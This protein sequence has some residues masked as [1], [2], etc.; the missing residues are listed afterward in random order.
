MGS[1]AE[2]PDPERLSEL[3]E[4]ACALSGAGRAAFLAEECGSDAQLKA[5][6]ASLLVA[7]D[8]APDWLEGMAA[9]VLPEALHDMTR[10]HWPLGHA[11]SRYHVDA[12]IGRGGMGVVYRARDLTLGRTVALKFL[13]PHLT[14]DRESRSRLE[15]EAKAASSLDHPNIAVIHEIGSVPAPDDPDGGDRLFIAMAYYGGE[16]L[17]ET[18]ARGPLPIADAVRY[19]K[20]IAD[21]L[22][23]AHDAGIVHRDIKPANVMVTERGEAKILDFGVSRTQGSDLTRQGVALG[24]L[25]YMSP[26]QTRGA[27]VDHRTDV[28]SLGV[29]LYEMLAGTRP[30]D[31][32]DDVVRIHAIRNEVPTPLHD[33]RP[34]CSPSL[35]RVVER[36]MA[37]DPAARYQH[38]AGIAADLLVETGQ[39]A[40]VDVPPAA[41]AAEAASAGE[42]G[43]RRAPSLRQFVAAGALVAAFAAG[44]GILLFRD[45]DG[46]AADGLLAAAD[47]EPGASRVV[48][49][50]FATASADSDLERL[51][52]DLALA[53]AAALDGIDDIRT[54]DPFATLE[55]IRD[56]G[57]LSLPEVRRL[58]RELNA[59]RF[60]HGALSRSG[61]RLRL[62]A[63]WY[64]TGGASALA[65]AS[66]SADD[67]DGLTQA[68]T[69]ALL[70]QLWQSK[71]PAL[72]GGAISMKSAVPSARRAY[73]DGERALAQYDLPAAIE[74]F[75]RAFA[76]DTTFW[77]AFWRSFTPRLY[78]EDPVEDG[79]LVQKI[80]DR[81]WE[82]PRADRL[83]LEASRM[84]RSD[85][86]RV[87][88]MELH[89]GTYPDHPLL[90]WSY[91]NA[92][93]HR[94]TY[95]GYS[96]GEA[97]SAFERV[98]VLL[99]RF[100]RAWDHLLWTA[101]VRADSATAVR[102]AHEAARLDGT[103]GI[104]RLRLLRASLFDH[105]ATEAERL[106]QFVDFI[107]SAPPHLAENVSSGLVADGF[108]ALQIQVNRAARARGTGRSLEAALWRG[109]A[110][111]W[112]A[113]G[114]WD[115]ALVATDRWVA[116]ASRANADAELGAYRLATAGVL[117]GGV[118]P[119]RAGA[120]RRAAAQAIGRT[121]GQDVVCDTPSPT[122]D[123]AA[124]AVRP[125]PPMFYCE[126]PVRRA[127]YQRS[128]MIWLDGLLAYLRQDAPG[129]ARARAALVTGRD[130]PRS[131]GSRF[132]SSWDSVSRPALDR[133]L[134]ALAEALAGDEET[135]AR[136]LSSLEMEVANRHSVSQFA[137]FHP[138]FAT[139]NRLLAARLLSR[140]DRLAD[141][142]LLLNWHEAILPAYS[143]AWN[144]AIG[145]VT[146]LD[147]AEIAELSGDSASAL[148]DNQRFLSWHDLP[149][150]ALRPLTDRAIAGV[151]R[152]SR[153]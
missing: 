67:L 13:R 50:P 9:G 87:R 48:V 41:A 151:Q 11:V 33:L 24:T 15:T 149:D 125:G 80:I 130:L 115:S 16:T 105:E 99:P 146:L 136:T 56:P 72:D 8:R 30:F 107:L 44:A 88:Q 152:L 91:A 102:A 126:G 19:A 145:N 113:R 31:A 46:V 27:P 12:V 26:E 60:I 71:P 45:N 3:F 92:L 112:A 114:A 148:R 89:L 68:A 84:S 52:R 55:Q 127:V 21:G 93:G 98:L 22:A 143:S 141:A 142:A 133:S 128:D 6:L 32:S 74:A 54:V 73:L 29:M 49:F 90:W 150:P 35:V 147:R 43:Q 95:L 153:R 66:I 79:V 42:R 2:R 110:L 139:A 20:Q 111:A 64:E 122:F 120:R 4:R 76:L 1:A 75:D 78:L 5:E 137:D 106:T 51:G 7:W 85:G 77:W 40:V 109:E 10:S 83:L 129:I 69:I 37:K 81:R 65:R 58:S 59:H 25:A 103:D 18:I 61:S 100:A 86:E 140:S 82:L 131:G 96:A 57:A 116:A 17:R 39:Q 118:T 132:V 28:W 101:I 38:A 135:A 104:R 117:L 34:E 138:L 94:A 23:S 134:A 63:W 14:D 62:D 70:D 124:Y 108:P 36:C 123:S 121:L 97:Q 144:R 47:A 119:E 53:L